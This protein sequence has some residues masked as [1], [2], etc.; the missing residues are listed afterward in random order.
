MCDSFCKPIVTCVSSSVAN[1]GVIDKTQFITYV[2]DLHAGFHRISMNGN[3]CGNKMTETGMPGLDEGLAFLDVIARGGAQDL[4]AMAAEV[5]GR[6]H[7]GTIELCAITNAKSGACPNDCSFC[8]QSAHHKTPIE[9]YPFRDPSELLAE[10][11]RAEAAGAHRFSIVTSGAELSSEDLVS[12]CTAIRL[13]WRETSLLPCASLGRIGRQEALALKEAGLVRY[14]HNL[15]T[16]RRFYAEVCT[17]Q[18]YDDRIA[19]VRV[20]RASGLEVCV[21]GIL[22]LGEPMREVLDLILEIG[23]L[24]PES[25]PLNFLDPRPGTPLAAQPLLT[26]EA[27]MT[28]IALFRLMLPHTILRLAGG[29]GK[30]LGEA[31]AAAIKMGINGLMIGNYL[32]TKGSGVEADSKMLADLGLSPA[33]IREAE[34]AAG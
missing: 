20:V 9:E 17:T 25:V 12:A 14:H 21:G 33:I 3:M 29:R 19:T 32:T 24:A 31:Q 23:N 18:T 22:G 15:E 16:S 11:V 7:A 2:F 30:T 4:F 27:A 28:D 5:Q 10:A 13:I 6:F 26:P 1:G 8:A 34:H